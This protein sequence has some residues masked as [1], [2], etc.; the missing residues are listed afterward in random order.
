MA[1]RTIKELRDLLFPAVRAYHH[2]MPEGMHLGLNIQND[3][4]IIVAS[5]EDLT[6]CDAHV[7]WRIDEDQS[8]LKD[9]FHK[10]MR[11]IVARYREPA[12]D[13]EDAA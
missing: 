7:L 12:A 2:R 6:I 11:A 9:E 8:T 1:D 10:R 3:A 5:S 4:L 13:Q